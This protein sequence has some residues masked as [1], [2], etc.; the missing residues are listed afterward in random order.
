MAAA[1][2]EARQGRRFG[3]A[4]RHAMVV[5]HRYVG[6]TMAVFLVV[7]CVTGSAIVF[8]EELDDALNRSLAYVTPPSGQAIPLARTELRARADAQLPP[9][10][11]VWEV[12]LAPLPSDRA[13]RFSLNYVDESAQVYTVAYVD[14]YSG[15]LIAVRDQTDFSQLGNLMP[16][17]FVLHDSL[18]LGEF[19]MWLLGITALL[20]TVDCFV[21]FYLTLPPSG[22]GNARK[23]WWAR[24][25]PAWLIRAGSLFA[26]LFSFHRAA[27]LWFWAILLVFAWSSV[28][29][30]L[31]SVYEPVMGAIFRTERGENLPELP[32]PRFEPRMTWEQ[33]LVRGEALMAEEARSQGFTIRSPALLSHEPHFGF[34][35]YQ[36]SS[37]LDP[38]SNGDTTIWM[39]SDSGRRVAFWAP[40]GRSTGETADAWLAQ[41][42]FG[43]VLGLPYRIFI[44]AV[45]LV[46][47]ALAVT[48]VIIWLKKRKSR[49]RK[50]RHVERKN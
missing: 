33:A 17:M 44:T 31:H 1:G 38:G 26:A 45:G 11:S 35:R 12:P 4:F 29:L 9:G 15:R 23:G 2:T 27:G 37:S 3:R 7:A 36:V 34:Y 14:P 21:G 30:L 40:A 6:L 43:S 24:W 39:D 28:G 19:G 18:M 49:R 22:T 25:A 48:G 20:W 5:V 42:H 8:M 41:L 10:Y 50:A 32:E 46:A 16:L 47:A 13:V